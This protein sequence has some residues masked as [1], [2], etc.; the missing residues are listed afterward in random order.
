MKT[1]QINYNSDNLTEV[2]HYMDIRNKELASIGI[3][4]V[5]EKNHKNMALIS[6]YDNGYSVIYVLNRF[7]GRNLYNDIVKQFNLKIITINECN[8][9]DYLKSKKHNY[10]LVSPSKAYLKIRKYYGNSIAKRSF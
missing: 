4:L 5:S 9:V 8:I 2:K 3:T 7:R 6:N 10:I 1:E